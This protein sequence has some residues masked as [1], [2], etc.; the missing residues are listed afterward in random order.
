MKYF[1]LTYTNSIINN[2]RGIREIRFKKRKYGFLG[3]SM[4]VKGYNK[5]YWERN[6]W[7]LQAKREIKLKNSN[8]HTRKAKVPFVLD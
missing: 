6:Y 8:C 3:G 7:K 5:Q 2:I 1:M 4:S